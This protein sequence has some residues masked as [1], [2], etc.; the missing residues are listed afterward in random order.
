MKITAAIISC[1]FVCSSL[2]AQ[3]GVTVEKDINKLISFTNADFDMGKIPY[4]K[5]LEYTVTLKNIST[6][7]LT[8]KEIKAGCGC[9]TPKYRSNEQLL[10]GGSTTIVLGFNGG[11]V[12]TFSKYA[13]IYFSN[14]L[15][16]QLHFHGVAV[17][18]ST[19]TQQQKPVN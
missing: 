9:T 8:V 5:P 17:A 13:D 3:V 10:P 19:A 18:D 11:A 1:F 6:D 4:G 2:N 12:G 16:K 7:T 15:S 14:G